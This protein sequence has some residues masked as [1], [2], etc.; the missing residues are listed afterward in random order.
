MIPKDKQFTQTS[1]ANQS[2]TTSW[3]DA[4]RSAPERNPNKIT[5]ILEQVRRPSSQQSN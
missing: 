1:D 5:E 2:T 3:E 4:L